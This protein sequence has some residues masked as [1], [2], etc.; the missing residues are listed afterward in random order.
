MTNNNNDLQPYMA[1]ESAQFELDP[2]QGDDSLVSNNNL[3]P[4]SIHN[5]VKSLAPIDTGKVKPGLMEF[6]MKKSK[7]DSPFKVSKLPPM[8]KF[9]DKS[10]NLVLFHEEEVP[11]SQELS[12]YQNINTY[13]T[14]LKTDFSLNKIENIQN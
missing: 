7:D 1:N 3:L 6:E 9:K 13:E 14:E 8:Y 5:R 4:R 11:R 12:T 10:L 2:S